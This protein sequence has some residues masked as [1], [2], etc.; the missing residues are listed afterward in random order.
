MYAKPRGIA[1]VALIHLCITDR[2]NAKRAEEAIKTPS[3]WGENWK[4]YFF[5]GQNTILSCSG[6]K[7]LSGIKA[8][9]NS[10][11]LRIAGR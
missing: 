8:D 7:D 3:A 2:L 10:N 11:D 1:M 6:N 5:H 4:N 9:H